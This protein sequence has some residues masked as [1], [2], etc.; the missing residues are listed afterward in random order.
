MQLFGDILA[1][2]ELGAGVFAQL[3]AGFNVLC[4][5]GIKRL[6]AVFIRDGQDDRSFYFAALGSVI[7]KRRQAFSQAVSKTSCAVMPRTSAIFAAS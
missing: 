7:P 2:A 4:G 5:H 6:G 1:Y 3:A